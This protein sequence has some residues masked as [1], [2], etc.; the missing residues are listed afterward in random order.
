MTKQT[1]CY[2]NTGNY[3]KPF[4]LIVCRLAKAILYNRK[5]SGGLLGRAKKINLMHDMVKMF[6]EF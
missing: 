1:N 6:N 2:T 5:R 4:V 3:N